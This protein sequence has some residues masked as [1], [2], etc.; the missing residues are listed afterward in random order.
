MA[1]SLQ[2][3]RCAGVVDGAAKTPGSDEIR[4]PRRRIGR[5]LYSSRSEHLVAVA[6]APA[7]RGKQG[8]TRR[9]RPSARARVTVCGAPAVDEARESCCAPGSLSHSTQEKTRRSGSR[10]VASYLRKASQTTGGD[11]RPTRCRRHHPASAMQ[12]LEAQ[13]ALLPFRR[14]RSETGIGRATP[15]ACSSGASIRRVDSATFA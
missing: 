14:C 8:A 2:L 10:A 7:R 9:F 15:G 6:D 1:G 5:S 3:T 13:A 4:E 11:D 12:E